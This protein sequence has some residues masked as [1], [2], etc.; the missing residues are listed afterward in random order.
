MGSLEKRSTSDF[1]KGGVRLRYFYNNLADA[2]TVTAEDVNAEFPVANLQDPRRKKI[3]RT[4]TGATGWIKVNFGAP[5]TF[6]SI[7]LLDHTLTTADFAA[8]AWKFQANATDAWG[9]PTVNETFSAF[10]SGRAIMTLAAP[11]TLRYAR[12]TFSKS[13]ATARDFGRLF[14][15]PVLDLGVPGDPSWGGY[16]KKTN[17]P[18]EVQK[19]IGAQSLTFL[20]DKFK[21]WKMDFSGQPDSIID[22]VE[23]MVLSVGV[24]KPFFFQVQATGALSTP[25]YCR[26]KETPEFQEKSLDTAFYWDHQLQLIEE[27]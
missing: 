26:M 3:Y 11:V 20:K 8:G 4:G 24:S 1:T 18:S 21:S 12:F 17:D 15:G 10:Q 7:I 14:L 22:L 23:A 5:V 9:S 25:E 2:V 6:Q 13:A 27:L 16:S 19:T